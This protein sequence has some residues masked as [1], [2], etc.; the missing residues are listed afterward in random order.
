MS[1]LTGYSGDVSYVILTGSILVGSILTVGISIRI[2]VCASLTAVPRTR[3]HDGLDLKGEKIH[4]PDNED[5]GANTMKN[6]HIEVWNGIIK[7][8]SLVKPR[9]VIL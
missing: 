5:H 1:N 6:F 2:V 9:L 4:S 7:P 8:S 3:M